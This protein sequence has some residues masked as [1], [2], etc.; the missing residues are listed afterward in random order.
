MRLYDPEVQIQTEDYTVTRRTF[1]TTLVRAAPSPQRDVL[2]LPRPAYVDE[3]EFPSGALRLKAWIAAGGQVSL[4][5]R[6]RRRLDQR[7]RQSGDRAERRRR[8]R[9]GPVPYRAAFASPNSFVI[10]ASRGT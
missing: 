6:R 3:I 2:P 9:V 4:P 10:G 7:S 8:R 1:R 5:V